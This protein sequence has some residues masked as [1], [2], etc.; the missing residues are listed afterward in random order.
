VCEEASSQS[1]V[2]NFIGCAGKTRCA[3]TFTWVYEG[4]QGNKEDS[5]EK[6][7]NKEVGLDSMANNVSEQCTKTIV[8][9]VAQGSVLKEGLERVVTVT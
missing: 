9:I 2:E 8:M 7:E 3:A 4:P 5:K 1:V 6:V